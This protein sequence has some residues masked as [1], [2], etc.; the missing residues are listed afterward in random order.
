M[1]SSDLSGDAAISGDIGLRTKKVAAKI[2]GNI[3]F[4]NRN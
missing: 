2:Y 3:L 1:R 4:F